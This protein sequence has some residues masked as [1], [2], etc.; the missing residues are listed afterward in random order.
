MSFPVS[1]KTQDS[2]PQ[3][4]ETKPST[5]D[6]VK[7]NDHNTHNHVTKLR[8]VVKPSTEQLL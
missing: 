8:R 7:D 4:R 2:R 1:Q 5:Q 6:S 3:L